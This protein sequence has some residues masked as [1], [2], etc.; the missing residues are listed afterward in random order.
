MKVIRGSIR[1]NDAGRRAVKWKR[2][3]NVLEG[4]RR[5]T[6]RRRAERA[7]IKGA[8]NGDARQSMTIP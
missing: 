5:A 4:W 7:S 8:V 3:E 1:Y 6:R 2:D